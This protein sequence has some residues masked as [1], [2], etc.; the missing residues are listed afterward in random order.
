MQSAKEATVQVEEINEVQR[1]PP[2]EPAGNGSHP[3]RPRSRRTATIT[4]IVLFAAVLIAR[5]LWARAKTEDAV[6]AE[7]DGLAIPSVSI[8][9]P[10]PESSQQE[11]VLPANV[12]PFINAPMYAQVTGYL[13]NWYVDIGGR[14]KKGQL[15]GAI[16]APTVDQQLQ[17]A[18]GNLATAEANLRLSE[19]TAK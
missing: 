4:V 3:R 1:I 17:Q 15:L 11:I 12:Q 14:V 9:E 8:T 16:D 19:I 5:G 7:T 18:R 2:I 10:Q 13:K 6:R